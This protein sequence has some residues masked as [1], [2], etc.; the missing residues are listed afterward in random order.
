LSKVFET[1]LTFQFEKIRADLIFVLLKSLYFT[2]KHLQDLGVRFKG[3]AKGLEVR[4]HTN[5]TE[6]FGW[7]V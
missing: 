6:I 5:K 7:S 3:S 1:F 2:L 4:K